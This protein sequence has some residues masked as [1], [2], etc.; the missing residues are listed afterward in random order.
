M[1]G[2]ATS[3]AELSF[4]GFQRKSHFPG[5]RNKAYNSVRV[6]R[7]IGWSN[8]SLPS[9]RG[10]WRNNEVA[11]RWSRQ[12][13]GAVEDAPAAV[14]PGLCNPRS[15]G[16]VICEARAYGT[17]T[18][19]RQ[20]VNNERLGEFTMSLIWS[21]HACKIVLR[22][23]ILIY[24]NMKPPRLGYEKLSTHRVRAIYFNIKSSEVKYKKL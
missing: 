2:A 4:S 10:E 19:R 11:G 15:N 8:D 23:F 7:W 22:D 18:Y 6:T 24:F 9:D 16:W 5:V 1:S 3:F 14:A 12:A 13:Y 17:Q 21:T 20:W